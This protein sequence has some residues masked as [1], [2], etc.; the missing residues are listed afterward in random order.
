MKNYKR[1]LTILL[2][3]WCLLALSASALHLFYNAD[4][5]L[6]IGVAV[7]AGAPLVI[8]FLWFAA[9]PKFRQFTLSLD[10]S[11]L[12]AVQVWRFIGFIFPL[13][14]ARGMLPA[15]FALPA[16]Y[17]DMFIGVTAAF[18][19]WKLATPNQRNSFIFW[20]I[21]GMADLATAVTMG[22]TSPFLTPHDS[23]ITPMTLLPLSIIPTFLVPLFF[24]LH[25]ICIAQAATWQPTPH[26]MRSG[27]TSLETITPSN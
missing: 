3:V 18:V 9:S 21:L 11:A 7:A 2:V 16:G 5:R 17:G 27:Q 6:G 13:M 20:Q 15:V 23:S 22:V 4:N 19:A 10:P 24:I 26:S 12:T 14:Q 8:F 25:S 1:L